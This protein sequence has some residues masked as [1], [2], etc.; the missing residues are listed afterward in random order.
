MKMKD[1]CLPCLV[2]Q[3]I[4]V[5]DITK[6]KNREQILHEVFAYLSSIDFNKTNSEISGET[7]R[8][9]KKY[10]GNEDTYSTLEEIMDYINQAD[11]IIAKGQANYEYLSECDK[12]G[13]IFC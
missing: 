2:N 6:A 8:I 13:I 9:I 3:V 12:S 11:V 1:K 5:A 7:F 10:L 4:K